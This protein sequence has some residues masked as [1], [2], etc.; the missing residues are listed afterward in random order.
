M[1]EKHGHPHIPKF[2]SSSA[3]ANGQLFLTP[4]FVVRNM[5]SLANIKEKDSILTVDHYA[6]TKY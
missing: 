1:S 2:E 4:I 5:S 3:L 6:L